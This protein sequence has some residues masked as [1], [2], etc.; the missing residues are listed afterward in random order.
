[1][2]DYSR[3]AHIFDPDVFKDKKILI[4]GMGSVGYPIA[5]HL[6]MSGIRKL[7]LFDP[8]TYDL[9][10][11]VKHP[12]WRKNIGEY[13]VD[14]FEEWALDRN[15]NVE[16]KSFKEDVIDSYNFDVQI[17]KCDIVVN[18][19]DNTETRM[20]VSD[21]AIQHNKIC[22]TSGVFRT[23]YGGSVLV[24]RPYNKGK[25]DA[26]VN[27]LDIIAKKNDWYQGDDIP[28]TDIENELI[29]GQDLHNFSV[30]GLSSDIGFI[31]LLTVKFILWELVRGNDYPYCTDLSKYNYL[32]FYNR[33]VV[34]DDFTIFPFEVRKMTIPKIR[35]CPVHPIEEMSEDET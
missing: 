26:C 6:V 35:D 9:P 32:V 30:S 25:Q 24:F 21:K 5:Q 8:D 10:N 28:L 19:P 22:I 11:L 12:G 15:P 4:V 18:L 34:T 29:Y 7:I 33:K 23:G 2:M 14:M 1:M 20:Y 17:M 3:I 13:K 31:N 16:I 27:C